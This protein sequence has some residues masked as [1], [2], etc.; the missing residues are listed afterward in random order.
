MALG[1][2][3]AMRKHKRPNYQERALEIASGRFAAK[4]VVHVDRGGFSGGLPFGFAEFVFVRGGGEGEVDA[5]RIVD[6]RAETARVKCG[7]A[8]FGRAA[9]TRRSRG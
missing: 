6:D 2:P 3:M 4:G 7:G 8:V 9:L 1:T 5:S